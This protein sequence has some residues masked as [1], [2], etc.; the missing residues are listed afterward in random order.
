MTGYQKKGRRYT[1]VGAMSYAILLKYLAEGTMN[2]QELADAVGLHVL[3]VYDYT[4]AMYKQ[5]VIHICAWE[6]DAIGRC[7]V[8]I[9]M[10]GK[11]KDAA[12]GSKTRIQISADYRARQKLIEMNQRMVA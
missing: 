7:S 4:K 2:C 1:K 6:T 5:G 9:Y 3:T 11:G 8:R 10:L 12:K